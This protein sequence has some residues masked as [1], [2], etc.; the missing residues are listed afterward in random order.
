MTNIKKK[1]TFQTYIGESC[2]RYYGLWFLFRCLPWQKCKTNFALLFDTN[3]LELVDADR[4][5]NN[6]NIT[7][8]NSSELQA[9]S[10]K[11]PLYLEDTWWHILGHP[12]P[13]DK[14]GKVSVFCS[15]SE[16]SLV[17]F[18]LQGILIIPDIQTL[19]ALHLQSPS[20]PPVCA[21]LC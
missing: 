8:Q 2:Q 13:A 11:V 1:I 3:S 20:A 7:N 6:R 9:S 12:D 14:I 10:E 15:S 18:L 16:S 4:K 19:N 21:R 17:R 5:L